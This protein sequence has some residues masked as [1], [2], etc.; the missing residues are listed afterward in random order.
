M[1]FQMNTHA[2][3]DSTVSVLNEYQKVLNDI[4]DPRW[5]IEHSQVVD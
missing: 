3:G 1:G 4:D 5:R 2:I